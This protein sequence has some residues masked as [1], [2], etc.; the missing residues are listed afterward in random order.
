M[1][2]E[3]S[4][5]PA[6][7]T[8]AIVTVLYR[9]EKFVPTLLESV[10]SV[11]YPRERLILHLVD[12]SPGDG[13]LARAR[14]KMA[15]LGDRLPTVCWHEP[16]E[17]IGFAKGN[18]LAIRS[19][20]DNGTDYV[21]LLNPDAT[22]EQSA[23]RTAVDHAR[24]HS[25]VGS[26]QSLLVLGDAPDRVNTYG[27]VIHFLGFGYVAGYQSLRSAVPPGPRAIGFSSGACVLLPAPVLRKV[28]LFDETLWLYHEDLDLGWRI[29]LAGFEN[30][31]VPDSVCRHHY[32]FSRSTSK[33]YWMER[34]RW[35]V[36]LKNY[37]LRT[38]LLLLPLLLVTDL[39]LLALAAKGGWLK[40]K[41]KALIW[42][43]HPRAW[44]YLHH[45]RRDIQQTRQV[46]DQQILSLYSATIDHP[47]FR[48]PLVTILVEP[49]WKIYLALLRKVV[50]W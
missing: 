24:H 8:V 21:F 49:V 46:T 34:N 38:I 37:R 13:T 32:E 40:H 19:A 5:A 36:V 2:A 10:A 48:N 14:V 39:G 30:I 45:G 31:V 15:Q 1:T 23:L 12:N 29:R 9:C 35:L 25:K 33:W 26:V 18:N 3:V 42:F 22:F 47:D 11:D 28:G 7:P 43:L 6:W 27:N 17:N 4:Q 41:I 20:L 44:G 16:G 50:W